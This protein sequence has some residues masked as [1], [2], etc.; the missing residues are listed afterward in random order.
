MNLY[1]PF[2]YLFYRIKKWQDKLFLGAPGYMQKDY[3]GQVH[4]ITILQTMNLSSTYYLFLKFDLITSKDYSTVIHIS[5]VSFFY[6]LNSYLLLWRK[7]TSVIIEKFEKETKYQL[8]YSNIFS[9]LYIFISISF[10]IFV[11]TL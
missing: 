6:L 8:L 4:F 7:K 3:F 1:R 2:E 5:T 9:I 10:L 11:L